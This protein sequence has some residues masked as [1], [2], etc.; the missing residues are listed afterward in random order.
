[1]TA[2]TEITTAQMGNNNQGLKAVTRNFGCSFNYYPSTAQYYIPQVYSLIS[3]QKETQSWF[4]LSMDHDCQGEN[5]PQQTVPDAVWA[6]AIN[7]TQSWPVKTKFYRLY[8]WNSL[9]ANASTAKAGVLCHQPHGMPNLQCLIDVDVSLFPYGRVNPLL[10]LS[11]Y[12]CYCM[13][14]FVTTNE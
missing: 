14:L 1:M 5:E 3:Y 7:S 11:Y 8:L 9:P 2:T 12:I 10:I 4:V 13:L 6:Q